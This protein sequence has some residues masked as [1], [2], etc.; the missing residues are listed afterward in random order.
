MRTLSEHECAI[1][2]RL[3]RL[4]KA[5][6]G[7][8]RVRTLPGVD[9]LVLVD[10]RPTTIDVPRVQVITKDDA[11]L[12]VTA[13]VHARVVEPTD[14]IMRV[15]DYVEATSQIAE[16][17]VRAVFTEHERD[18]AL[19]EHAKLES[20]LQQTIGEATADWGVEVSAV[21]IDVG[22]AR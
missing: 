18:E 21:E 14:A 11:P 4:H 3:G 20:I 8:A 5:V 10:L 9:Q 22:D 2:F 12:T 13:H 1:V 17:A 15:A 6:P 19:F 7:P 16:T